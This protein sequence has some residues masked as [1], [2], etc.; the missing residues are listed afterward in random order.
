MILAC[1]QDS[2][3]ACRAPKVSGSAA[4]NACDS[5][6]RA[7]AERSLTVRTHATS[8]T[9]AISW[10]VRSCGDAAGGTNALAALTYSARSRTFKAAERA[11][12]LA[13]SANPSKHASATSRN[14]S[15][16][17]GSGREST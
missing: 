15:P 7:L 5:V 4:V 10:A 2:V 11:S 13:N 6:S 16:P 17:N 12:R 8:A 3:P 14:G 9:K 1:C